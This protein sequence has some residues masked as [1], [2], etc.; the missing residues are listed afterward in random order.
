MEERT[1]FILFIVIIILAVVSIMLNIITLSSQHSSSASTAHGVN[2]N[3]TKLSNSVSLRLNNFTSTSS[4]T[5]SAILNISSNNIIA[6]LASQNANATKTTTGVNKNLSLL[7]NSVS[8]INAKLG[9]QTG[10]SKN[11]TLIISRLNQTD[12]NINNLLIS[13]KGGLTNNTI[14][15]WTTEQNITPG[16]YL[17]YGLLD[18]FE[19]MVQINASAPVNIYLMSIFQF[20]NYSKGISSATTQ[21]YTSSGKYN[22]TDFTVSL[23]DGCSLYELVITGNP[24]SN[25]IIHIYPNLTATVMPSAILTGIC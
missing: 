25:S 5:I 20:T 18:T 6:S 9:N 22:S 1:Y 24:S 11:I 3:L 14:R 16:N 15:T 17:V 19:N 23:T 12:N 8:S 4:N 7:Q 13:D 21:S 10:V 2:N